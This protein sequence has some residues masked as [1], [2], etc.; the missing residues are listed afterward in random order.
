MSESLQENL[1]LTPP[2]AFREI[3]LSGPIQ[4]SSLCPGDYDNKDKDTRGHDSKIFLVHSALSKPKQG[5]QNNVNIKETVDQ[6]I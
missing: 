3:I 5:N 1:K 4:K 2:P 6:D